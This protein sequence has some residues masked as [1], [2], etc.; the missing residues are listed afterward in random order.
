VIRWLSSGRQ[1]ELCGPGRRT[2]FPSTLRGSCPATKLCLQASLA[3]G[4]VF[5]GMAGL[6]DFSLIGSVE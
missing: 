3:S 5:G 6:L 2:N 1:I 4:A